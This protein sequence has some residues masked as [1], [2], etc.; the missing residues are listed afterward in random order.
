MKWLDLP[1]I[2]LLGA[3]GLAWGAGHLLPTPALGAWGGWVGPLLVLFGLLLTVAAVARLA[4]ARTTIVPHRP[5]AALVTDGIFR[6][7]RNP[8]YLADVLFLAGAVLYWGPAAPL[9]LVP[10]LAWVLR[11]RFILPEEGRLRAA[12]PRA[13]EAYA[14]RTRRWI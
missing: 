3:L 13:F 9:V 1:P 5:P 6:W 7:S 11:V 4:R 2:W 12:F 10:A 14:D 8:I